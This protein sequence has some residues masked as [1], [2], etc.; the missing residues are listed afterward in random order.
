MSI[1]AISNGTKK[2]GT[3]ILN[4]MSVTA[5]SEST[6]AVMRST[7]ALSPNR[8]NGEIGGLL[9]I[10]VLWFRILPLL[11]L[12]S[13]RTNWILF[14]CKAGY[15]FISG[16][17]SIAYRKKSGGQVGCYISIQSICIFCPQDTQNQDS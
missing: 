11:Q 4:Y 2:D 9:S 12:L 15:Y 10:S 14:N 1:R 13:T 16:S 5:G 6:N 3:L 17:D 8:S 7:A